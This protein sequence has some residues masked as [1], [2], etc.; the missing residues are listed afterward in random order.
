MALKDSTKIDTGYFGAN[1]NKSLRK[2]SIKKIA[3]YGITSAKYSMLFQRLISYFNFTSI[4][5]LG[6]SIGINTLYL[7]EKN[8][9]TRVF[10]FEGNPSLCAYASNV[11]GKARASNITLIKGNIEKELPEI[12]DT[13]LHPDFVFFDAN[14]KYEPTIKYFEILNH[15]RTETAV[16]VFDDI[17]WS[18]EMLKAWEIIRMHPDVKIDIDIF[19]MGILILDRALPRISC[20][21]SY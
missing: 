3:R 5:E 9:N 14:H 6:T 7:A 17:R 4:L 20:R 16:F 21:L 13:G 19:R 11:F 2:I 18:G 8:A 10:T 15:A 1:T 12:L